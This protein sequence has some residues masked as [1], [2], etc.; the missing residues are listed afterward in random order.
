MFYLWKS[1]AE[2]N[3]RIQTRIKKTGQEI[4]QGLPTCS[5]CSP[6]AQEWE[7]FGINT[8]L[9]KGNFFIKPNYQCWLHF[10]FSPHPLCSTS[11]KPQLFWWI[12]SG[13]PLFHCHLQSLSPDR[14]GLWL[15]LLP[16]SLCL[17]EP[18]C[19]SSEPLSG[20]S[21]SHPAGFPH[22][23]TSVNKSNAVN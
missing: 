9:Y 21:E 16:R 7:Y 4:L 2:V 18:G 5:Q 8:N 19:R 6:P 23:F 17:D 20:L 1:F 10:S 12:L 13:H 22:S 15:Q 3:H 11:E 14:A